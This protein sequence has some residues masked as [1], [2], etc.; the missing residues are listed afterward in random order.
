MVADKPALFRP[1]NTNP[2]RKPV[3]V[4]ESQNYDTIEADDD[5]LYAEEKE[6]RK[7]K[8]KKEI[9]KSTK[10]AQT[11]V[12][13][14]NTPATITAT[15]KTQP[16]VKTAAQKE[17]VTT[18]PAIKKQKVKS[19]K[20]KPLSQK[21]LDKLLKDV[22]SIPEKEKR[23]A[24]EK[25]EKEYQEKLKAH[26]EQVKEAKKKGAT[27]RFLE[28]LKAEF[29][30]AAQKYKK[31]KQITYRMHDNP[32]KKLNR[33]G[34][35]GAE[36]QHSFT[37]SSTTIKVGN[38][39][40]YYGSIN[41]KMK[42]FHLQRALKKEVLKNIKEKKLIVPKYDNEKIAYMKYSPDLGVMSDSFTCLDVKE[43]D[44]SKA[45]YV[46]AYR[47]G[48]IGKEMYD[49]CMDLTKEQRLR[50]IGSMATVKKVYT[51]R[52][53]KVISLKIRRNKL[54]RFV[55]FHICKQVDECLDEL[56]ALVGDRFIMYYVDG[57]YLRK[58][59]EDLNS[60]TLQVINY[61]AT[62]KYIEEK[63]GFTFKA[64][65]TL[66]YGAETDATHGFRKVFM[67]KTGKKR[68]K[69]KTTQFVRKDGSVVNRK[70]YIVKN[71]NSQKFRS[72]E[73]RDEV[74]H[75]DS[76]GKQQQDA[77]IKKHFKPTD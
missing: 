18:K 73:W 23:T 41:Y 27:K 59:E 9:L 65:D 21:A 66:G 36:Y 47:L 10:V 57:I 35:I 31:P 46:C 52:G 40:F 4:R 64:V 48:Y 17:V 11:I 55:W 3:V 19:K 39:T 30:K 74:A 14:T 28:N 62:I 50:F 72:N 26:Q 6:V 43:Y 53:F 44:L 29:N 15:E 69:N 54:L 32:N 22:S 37:L 75:W 70:Q 8:P 51:K 68:E 45:Y 5:D 56:R 76:L 20:R 2:L 71:L 24:Q 60:D 67:Y 33:L 61:D 63:Y 77:L 1:A 12:G 58:W 16:P 38:E 49:T 25:R 7:I 34:K 13:A 42:E